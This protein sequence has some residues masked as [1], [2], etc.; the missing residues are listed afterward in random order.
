[1]DAKVNGVPVTPRHGCPVEVNAL[2][3][4]ALAFCDEL[5]AE[6][7]SPADRCP[8]LLEQIRRSFRQRFWVENG[9]YLGDVYRD[10]ALDTSIRPNQIFAVSLP[11]SVLDAEHRDAVVENVRRHLL[12]PYGLR[13]L[14]PRHPDYIG[15]YEGSPASRDGAYH[16]G[17][18]W[19]WLL[20]AYGEAELRITRNRERSAKTLLA[21]LTPLFP[22]HLRE[23][24][25][26]T[27]SEIFDGNPPHQP[28]GCTAQAWSV[29]ELIRLLHLLKKSAPKALA[30]FEESVVGRT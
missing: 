24:G 7:H 1:M 8:D 13:T 17:T 27:V 30:A 5:A 4:N 18:V 26:G 22:A 23:A 12:T 29:G 6:F 11:H 3:Y 9:S 16:Q 14:S 19:P 21:T 15:L 28:N 20:G 2:W 10:G 25:M